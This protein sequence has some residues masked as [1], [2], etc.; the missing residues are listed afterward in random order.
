MHTRAIILIL[1]PAASL[2]L[3][4]TARPAYAQ[5]PVSLW[6]RIAERADEW[7]L[8]HDQAQLQD[9]IRRGDSARANR[10]FNRIQRDQ[11]WLTIDRSEGR[12]R[13]PLPFPQPIAADT[14][15]FSQATPLASDMVSPAS[16]SR[17]DPRYHPAPAASSVPPTGVPINS[18]ASSEPRASAESRVTVIIVNPSLTGIPVNY[19]ID[20]VPYRTTNGGF[21]SL[22]IGPNSAI[23]YDRGGSFGTQA[24]ALS[25]GGY[26]FR[27]SE[28]G[29]A[30]VKLC[31]TP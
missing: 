30:L 9:D 11:W 2:L 19:V 21:Q 12:L 24:Y 20:G 16:P 6:Y 10:D 4:T 23:R 18:P 13:P 27:S 31:G 15:L 22:G 29:W 3:L 25:S 17:L 14:T 28:T 5:G 8:E 7:Q 1:L 26:E